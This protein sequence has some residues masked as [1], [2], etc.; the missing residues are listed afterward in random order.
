VVGLTPIFK[1]FI[2]LDDFFMEQ[3][4]IPRV[5]FPYD[6]GDEGPEYSFFETVLDNKVAKLSLLVIASITLTPGCAIAST[7]RKAASEATRSA[8]CAASGACLTI[9]LQKAQC[10]DLKV[11]TAA[12][13][14][15]VFSQCIEKTAKS[16]SDS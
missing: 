6:Y 4:F 13:C 14:G 15:F 16:I 12:F 3:K 2:L 11:A 1:V 7:G 10:G 8:A 5:G 9:A